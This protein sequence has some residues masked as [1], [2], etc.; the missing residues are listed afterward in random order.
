MAAAHRIYHWKHGWIPLDHYAALKKA[1]GSESGA[2]RALA[3]SHASGHAHHSVVGGTHHNGT[4]VRG[5]QPVAGEHLPRASH[6]VAA[7]NPGSRNFSLM[8]QRGSRVGLSH[9]HDGKPLL[10]TIHE[11]VGSRLQERG[12]SIQAIRHLP[13]GDRLL[14]ANA[15]GNLKLIRADGTDL[16]M[17]DPPKVEPKVTAP[18]APTVRKVATPKAPK[19]PA[20]PAVEFGG[21]P[22]THKLSR[23]NGT[24]WD[25]RHVQSSYVRT[26]DGYGSSVRV[27]ERL[28]DHI[29]HND[30]RIIGVRGQAVTTVNQAGVVERYK[31]DGSNVANPTKARIKAFE[32]KDIGAWVHT[33][34]REAIVDDGSIGG[35]K[36]AAKIKR[37]YV[38]GNKRVLIEHSMTDAQT[39]AFLGEIEKS[40]KATEAQTGHL[41]ISIIVPVGD[42]NMRG[43]YGYVWKGDPTRVHLNP[44]VA[45]G[46][47]TPQVS[48]YKMPALARPGMTQTLYTLTHELGHIVDNAHQHT[49]VKGQFGNRADEHIF[50]RSQLTNG[51]SGYGRSQPVEGYA[52]A[53]A[54]HSLHPGSNAAANEYARR[55]GWR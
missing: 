27:D 15:E 28:A 25:G 32:R 34:P 13:D 35:R 16:N 24:G 45:D 29:E 21:Y 36:N 31:A 43:A 18:K 1:K 41:P 12:Y 33:E 10:T 51:L 52:E 53:F 30:L 5:L 7:F 47:A 9:V 17:I 54:Q 50:H 40:L 14:V 19:A 38:M 11:K 39:E 49:F 22:A 48:D 42:R 46:S 20:A 37:A 8:D 2:R 26:V 44:K 3:R 4:H 23:H 55:Y 6:I